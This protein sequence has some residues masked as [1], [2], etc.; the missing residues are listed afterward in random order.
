MGVR[1]SLVIP[2]APYRNAEIIKSIKNLEYPKKNFQVIIINGKNP[3]DNRNIGAKKSKG[4]ILGFLDDD[5]LVEKNFLTNV[6]N[7]FKKYP[8]IDIV[9]GPQLT[10]KND[11]GFARIS[12]YALS[13]K[14]GAAGVN[15]RYRIGK[16]NLDA[17]E[18]DLTSANLFARKHVMEKIKFDTKL[19]PGEDPKFIDDAKKA[20]FKVAYC[21]DFVIYHRRRPT[22]KGFI[23]Q[24]YSYGKARPLKEPTR[25]TIKKPVFL[26]PS[27]FIF[28]LIFL[29]AIII[30]KTLAS[31]KLAGINTLSQVS[32]FPL[33]PLL[34]Y[35]ILSI[36]FG[37][38]DSSKNKEY[39]AVIFLPIIYAIIHLSYGLGM[40][41]GFIKK[42]E[43]KKI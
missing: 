34:L 22:L 25:D 16:L 36:I 2:V 19:W 12:G 43:G 7:F 26:V 20:G 35:F 10:P 37:I 9:G 1:F 6:D 4:E 29:I 14:F 8:E 32:I 24:I 42:I 33:T 41:R 38:Y 30:K 11:R 27:I 5:G 3:S 39:K 23:G 40:I 28:Y 21:P 17:N 15:K 18:K 13:S 31:G